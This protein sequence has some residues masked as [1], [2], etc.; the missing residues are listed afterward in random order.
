MMQ[1]NRGNLSQHLGI[2][3]DFTQNT[4]LRVTRFYMGDSMRVFVTGGLP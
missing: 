1:R 2:A 4:T 3:T